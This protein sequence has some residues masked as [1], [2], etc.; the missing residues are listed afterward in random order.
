[1]NHLSRLYQ[2]QGNFNEALSLQTKCFSMRLNLLGENH[3]DTLRS[4]NNLSR[5]YRK[6]GRYDEAL[7]LQTKCLEMMEKELGEENPETLSS[8]NNLAGLMRCMQRYDEAYSLYAKC[9]EIRERVLP[10][11]HPDT[12]ITKNDFA[13]LLGIMR[14]Y[15]EALALYRYCY[16][17]EQEVLGS[18][19]PNTLKT[20]ANLE[21]ISKIGFSS[22]AVFVPATTV[23]VA[24]A[25]IGAVPV[26]TPAAA[27]P[28]FHNATGITEGVATD[29]TE[30]GGLYRDM[31]TLDDFPSI[32]EDSPAN[33]SGQCFL[34]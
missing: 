34:L 13:G 19:H 4:M 25:Y 2:A 12:L 7:P 15:N 16:I 9:L 32:L 30:A 21:K 8:M 17:V 24:R 28:T 18:K 27:F 3:P 5:L 1:M 23:A 22:A 33:E 31:E 20:K 6:M 29:V 10:E 14:R 11:K 26:V